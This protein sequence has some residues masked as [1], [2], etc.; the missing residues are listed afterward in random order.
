MLRTVTIA[1]C[2]CFLAVACGGG[3]GPADPAQSTTTVADAGQRELPTSSTTESAVEMS[4]DQ[5]SGF[6]AEESL[7]PAPA[8]VA[9]EEAVAVAVADLAKR[10]GVAAGEVEVVV[11]EAITWP[12]GSLGCPEP[13]M[14]YTQALERGRR[15]VLRHNDVGFDYHSGRDQT[16]F[17][18]EN[19]AARSPRAPDQ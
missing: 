4:G 19:P 2:L 7:E 15:I 17:Y 3:G 11:D 14:S 10:L 1:A 8:P 9:A 13:G 12:D 5:E 6:D 16:P 18:C